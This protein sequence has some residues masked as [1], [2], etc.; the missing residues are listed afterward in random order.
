MNEFDGDDESERS[1]DR[2]RGDSRVEATRRSFDTNRW[3]GL[4]GV[5]LAIIG[6]GV[7]SRRPSLVLA[8]TVG[9]GYAVYQQYG[10]SP[11]GAL[12]VERELSAPTPE[13]G[14][15]VQVR[16]RIHNNTGRLLP[17][18]RVIDGVPAALEAIEGPARM[19]TALQPGRTASFGYTVQ[20]VRGS[21]E[22]EPVR[23]VS[24]NLSGSREREI[25][26]TTQTTLRCLPPLDS[27]AD[28]PLRGL[29]TQYAGRV[30]TDL[31]GPGVEFHSTREYRRGDPLRRI[32]W[33]RHARTGELATLELRQERA[34]TVVLCIDARS[35]AYR[36]SRPQG[37]NAVEQSV[38]AA[39]EVFT[40]LTDGGDRVGVTAL[41]AGDCWLAPGAGSAHEA[42]V[43]ELLASDPALA[44]TPD[45]DQFYS[46][47]WLQR[48]R[49]RLPGAAQVILFSPMTD[50]YPSVAARRLDAHGHLVTVVSPDPTSTD[51]TGRQLAQL[52]R[53]RR[54]RRL[55]GTGIRAV[56][57]TDG[58]F[59]TAVTET[60]RRKR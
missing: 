4:A 22:W 53:D 42:R 55:R 51:T 24:R 27:G 7:V 13:P 47:L 56:D 18:I 28:L 20:A 16:V 32:D 40:A 8:G 14:D 19:A 23:V 30:P 36:A 59:A 46:S 15:E 5:I 2:D 33:N 17:D 10:D 44:P 9:I 58:A 1:S 52:E 43:R 39:A 54:I 41:A 25:T 31:G 48:F 49:R 35:K 50:E 34:A 60:A 37:R 6:I 12:A 45:S 3:L 26:I 21:H 38:D 57:W 29:T 11:Q